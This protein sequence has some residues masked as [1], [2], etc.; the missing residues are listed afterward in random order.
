MPS[1]A[2][3]FCVGKLA[4]GWAHLNKIHRVFARGILGS[5]ILHVDM[6]GAKT[7]VLMARIGIT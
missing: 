5:P 6:N 4:G 2:G 3:L 1:Q 7:L